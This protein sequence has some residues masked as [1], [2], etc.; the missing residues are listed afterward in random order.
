MILL[1]LE[2]GFLMPA[3]GHIKELNFACMDSASCSPIR[4]QP[5]V[6]QRDPLDHV[7]FKKLH[8]NYSFDSMEC[9]I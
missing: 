1:S 8:F 4:L 7:V 5:N 2:T 6:M 9:C 3:C